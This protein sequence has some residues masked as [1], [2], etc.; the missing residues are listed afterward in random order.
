MMPALYPELQGLAK[1]AYLRVQIAQLKA[2]YARAQQ[3]LMANLAKTD[4]TDFSRARAEAIIKQ[5]DQIADGLSKDAYTWAKKS[6]P[7]S[8]NRGI[9][10]AGQRL[11]DLGVRRFVTKDAKVHTEAINILVD[12][13]TSQLILANQGMKA[14]VTRFIRAT[15]QK[16]LE[17]AQISK[18]IAQGVIEGG[19]RRAVSDSILKELRSRMEGGN[20]I[21]ING[22]QYRP[23][24]YAELVARTRTREATTQ[25]S[26]NTALRYGLDLVQLDAHSEICEYCQQFSG[27]VYSISGSDTQFPKLEEQP[28]FHPNCRCI[29]T[30]V[31]RQALE[32]RG[33][34]TELARLSNAPSVQIDSYKRLESVLAGGRL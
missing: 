22:R 18:L 12:D 20:F 28:P 4:L 17:D 30:P 33:S 29:L 2:L 6:L 13:I 23:D 15:Q 31:T 14:F 25:G 5:V 26:I 34:V 9:D 16:I 3:R 32:D 11:K 10:L 19:T 27:R 8:Y 7:F 1:E 21:T 24:K